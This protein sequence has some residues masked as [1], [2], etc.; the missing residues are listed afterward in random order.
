MPMQPMDSTSRRSS[1]R[2]S[3]AWLFWLALLVP[4]AQSVATVHGYSHVRTEASD[5][6]DSDQA[7]QANHCDLCLTAAALAGG[8]LLAGESKLLLAAGPESVP[9]EVAASVWQGLP[10][11]GYLSRAPPFSAL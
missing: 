7:P 6:R 11:L 9:R 5:H 4:L 10:T 8:G 3:V 2:H 1:F